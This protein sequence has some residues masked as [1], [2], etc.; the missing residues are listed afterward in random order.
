VCYHCYVLV[1]CVCID[2]HVSFASVSCVV[3]CVR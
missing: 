3:V 2:S 1:D